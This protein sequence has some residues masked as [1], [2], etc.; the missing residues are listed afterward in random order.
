MPLAS[1]IRWHQPP[2]TPGH[3][4][5]LVKHCSCWV[6][7]VRA[8]I[9]EC[10]PARVQ[11]RAAVRAF[12]HV[13]W[14]AAEGRK[15]SQVSRGKCTT[16]TQDRLGRVTHLATILTAVPE[17]ESLWL[18]KTN[19]VM[20]EQIPSRQTPNVI[21]RRLVTLQRQA[22]AFDQITI[23]RGEKQPRSQSMFSHKNTAK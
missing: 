18:N 14:S 4:T 21:S 9:F 5:H 22:E 19:D 7:C 6:V 3:S 13:S 1:G 2:P 20:I 16:D 11:A 17:L 15:R 12:G 23:N 8:F 10:V